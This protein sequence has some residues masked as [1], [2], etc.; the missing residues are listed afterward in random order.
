MEFI[1]R[2]NR[3]CSESIGELSVL[4]LGFWDLDNYSRS[5]RRLYDTLV[6]ANSQIIFISIR[7]VQSESLGWR[8]TFHQF[9]PDGRDN[10][11]C[12]FGK[13]PVMELLTGLTIVMRMNSMETSERNHG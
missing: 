1:T 10:P 11:T 4:F 8:L 5:D 6:A 9:L 7:G 12:I 13:S 3:F 2:V